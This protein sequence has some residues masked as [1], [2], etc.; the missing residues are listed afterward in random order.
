MPPP[1]QI[2]D[3]T[4]V[5]GSAGPILASVIGEPPKWFLT[6][7]LGEGILFFNTLFSSEWG[8]HP[9]LHVKVVAEVLEQVA[10]EVLTSSFVPGP[11]P[12][13]TIFL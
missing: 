12:C 1:S 13:S 3:E 7:G 9:I 11:E 8:I 4:P 5:V 10:D 2:A 6:K